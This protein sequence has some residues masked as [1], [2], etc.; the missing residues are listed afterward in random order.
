MGMHDPATKRRGRH[1][2]ARSAYINALV[3]QQ[4]SKHHQVF[5]HARHAARLAHACTC[6]SIPI[7]ASSTAASRLQGT[8]TSCRAIASGVARLLFHSCLSC[9]YRGRLQTLHLRYG[10]CSVIYIKKYSFPIVKL[11][12]NARALVCHLLTS[13]F[14]HG[15]VRQALLQLF[16]R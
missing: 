6:C 16:Q 15:W 7:M 3:Q 9:Q 13:S 2:M 4:E 14:L 5:L 11:R 1:F 12:G 8:C 10:T